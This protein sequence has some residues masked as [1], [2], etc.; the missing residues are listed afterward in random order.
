MLI[1][2]LN[3][4]SLVL[5]GYT[6]GPGAVSVVV[7]C[8]NFRQ[9]SQPL[10]ETSRFANKSSHS[11]YNRPIYSLQ[12]DLSLKSVRRGLESQ[13]KVNGREIRWIQKL[14]FLAHSIPRLKNHDAINFKSVK[15]SSMRMV[16]ERKNAPGLKFTA[17]FT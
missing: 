4:N 2:E 10:V 6:A 9:I 5:K 17:R 12:D 8:P 1:A 16:K 14:A 15:P 11:N 7:L 3:T 13:Y